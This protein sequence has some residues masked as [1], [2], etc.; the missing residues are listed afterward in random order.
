MS[1]IDGELK[2]QSKCWDA[3]KRAHV[4]HKAHKGFWGILVH[5]VVSLTVFNRNWTVFLWSEGDSLSGKAV[6]C[7]QIVCVCVSECV[8]RRKPLHQ[9]HGLIGYQPPAFNKA[10]LKSQ[11]VDNTSSMVKE[12]GDKC[13]SVKISPVLTDWCGAQMR[14]RTSEPHS[15]GVALNGNCD[16]R[17]TEM[18]RCLVILPGM[19]P[20]DEVL[21]F[22]T[23]VWLL[24]HCVVGKREFFRI[25]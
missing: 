4:Y 12:W 10:F 14:T 13:S 9:Q 21:C 20:D 3:S 15:W 25:V 8:L 1:I 19:G 18:Q 6:L 11:P 16:E 22:F 17:K 23:E 24:I 2:R 5:V 7:R